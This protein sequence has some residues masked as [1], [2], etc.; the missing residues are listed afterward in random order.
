MLGRGARFSTVPVTQIFPFYFVLL[1]D[2]FV[3]YLQNCFSYLDLECK[4]QQLSERLSRNG[5]LER[6]LAGATGI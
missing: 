2:S 1:S 4:Q 5:T 3:N 6:T